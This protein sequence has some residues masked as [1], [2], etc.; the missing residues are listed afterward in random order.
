MSEQSKILK[1][2][3]IAE[4]LRGM[5]IG[6]VQYFEVGMGTDGK[7]I[8]FNAAQR[9]ISATAHRINVK[10]TQSAVK[11]TSLSATDKDVYPLLRVQRI[12]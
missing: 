5:Q 11:A 12:G 8:G 1:T 10:V 2:R 3:G 7:G 9:N 6:D 4:K